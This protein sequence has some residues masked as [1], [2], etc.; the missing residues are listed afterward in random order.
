MKTL[1]GHNNAVFS[2][3]FNTDATQIVSGSAD[4]TI[5]IWDSETGLCLKTLTGHNNWVRSVAFNTDATQIIS[6][7][8]D[9]TIKIWDI[10]TGICLR[11]LKGHT[12][13]VSSV[14][15]EYTNKKLKLK[16]LILVIQYSLNNQIMNLLSTSFNSPKVGIYRCYYNY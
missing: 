5:K 16:H 13:T 2:V 10:E 15:I 7:S 4:S 1:I 14:A 9:N 3:A 11:T 12:N 6:G 8:D